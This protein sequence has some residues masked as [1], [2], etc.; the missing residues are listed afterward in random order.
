M[1]A[2]S[3]HP[4]EPLT[5]IHHGK[6][7]SDLCKQKMDIRRSDFLRHI[8]RA[9]IHGTSLP[10]KF[11]SYSP[12]S[13]CV[14]DLPFKSMLPSMRYIWSLIFTFCCHH[15]DLMSHQK[16]PISPCHQLQCFVLRTLPCLDNVRSFIKST[17]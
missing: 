1:S 17:V 8:M 9:T 6:L 16:E 5:R 10:P 15:D 14:Y 2:I 12:Y 7:R 3:I 13:L 11:Y 4:K